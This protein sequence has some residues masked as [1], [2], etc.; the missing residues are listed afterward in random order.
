MRLHY[1][2][3]ANLWTTN[4]WRISDNICCKHGS[5]T[6]TIRYKTTYDRIVSV[7]YVETGKYGI[8]RT[9]NESYIHGIQ[10]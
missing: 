5:F 9:K 3:K 7:K 8:I 6:M 2:S 1:Q 4:S 10:P